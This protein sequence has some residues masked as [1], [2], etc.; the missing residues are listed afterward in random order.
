MSLF[1]QT[2]SHLVGY[3]RWIT[4]SPLLVSKR[5]QFF[6][7]ILVLVCSFIHLSPRD[8]FERGKRS[9]AGLNKGSRQ[10]FYFFFP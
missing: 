1:F 6:S 10:P 9:L 8:S 7:A 3:Q 2:Q 5:R 4:I